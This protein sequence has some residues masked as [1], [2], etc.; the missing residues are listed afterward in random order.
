MGAIP[1]ENDIAKILYE[2]VSERTDT[3]ER[4]PNR[5]HVAVL[6]R[7]MWNI[8]MKDAVDYTHLMEKEY[9][10]ELDKFEDYK[11]LPPR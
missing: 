4:L 3:D 11:I 10:G 2:K 7:E 1:E 5:L 6:A 8:S 9:R